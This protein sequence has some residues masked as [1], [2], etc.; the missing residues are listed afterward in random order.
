MAY[1]DSDDEYDYGH[2][3]EDIFGTTQCSCCRNTYNFCESIDRYNRQFDEPENPKYTRDYIDYVYRQYMRRLQSVLRPACKNCSPKYKEYRK[4]LLD[5][6]Y[7]W[8]TKYR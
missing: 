2:A 3:P 8:W 6:A 1:Y 5:D 4:Q 7:K